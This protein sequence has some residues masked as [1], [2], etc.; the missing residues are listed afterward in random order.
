M[1]L[2]TRLESFF[3]KQNGNKTEKISVYKRDLNM[4]YFEFMDY[5]DFL[6]NLDFLDCVE[7][8]DFARFWTIV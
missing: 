2:Q 6:D 1:R 7:K 8:D 4:D 5:F 3:S